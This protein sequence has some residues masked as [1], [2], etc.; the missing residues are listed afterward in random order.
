MSR[1]TK[2]NIYDF[3]DEKNEKNSKYTRAVGKIN[4]TNGTSSEYVRLDHKSKSG[5][6]LQLLKEDWTLSTPGVVISVTGAAGEIKELT[7]KDRASYFSAIVDAAVSTKAWIITGGTDAGVMKYTGDAVK[8]RRDTT[9]DDVTTIGIATW[10][11]I[12]ESYQT[13]LTL[14]D[15]EVKNAKQLPP[16]ELPPKQRP[17]GEKGIEL[18][19]DHTHFILVDAHQGMK[20]GGEIALRANLEGAISNEWKEVCTAAAKKE[21]CRIPVVCI[22]LNGGP[23]T[24]NT[25]YEAVKHNTPVIIVNKTGRAADMMAKVFQEKSVASAKDLKKEHADKLTECLEKD[26]LISVFNSSSEKEMGKEMKG[27]ILKAVKKDGH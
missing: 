5:D 25:V 1:G 13:V 11:V 7:D 15:D 26:H 18:N 2:A 27:A 6:I 20:F 8:K 17:E 9:K 4:F 24:I 16:K 22:V 19:P 10:G 21:G 12:K 3:I 23:G 14:K